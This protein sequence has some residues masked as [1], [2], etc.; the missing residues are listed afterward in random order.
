VTINFT[1]TGST[2]TSVSIDWDSCEGIPGSDSV[3]LNPNTGSS[4]T[5]NDCINFSTLILSGTIF[6][7]SINKGVCCVQ[8]PNPN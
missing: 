7:N 4:Y 1:N 2:G 3:N 8:E 6:I 5:I